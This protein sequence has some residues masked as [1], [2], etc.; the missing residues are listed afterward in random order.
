MDV[1]TAEGDRGERGRILPGLPPRGGRERAWIADVPR[2]TSDERHGVQAAAGPVPQDQPRWRNV[3]GRGGLLPYL[4]RCPRKRHFAGGA[5][6][7]ETPATVGDRRIRGSP[8]RGDLFGMPPRKSGEARI[9]GLHLMP[10]CPLGRGAGDILP[11]VPPR[12]GRSPVRAAPEDEGRVRFLPQGTRER[13]EDGRNGS[14][15]LRMPSRDSQDKEDTSRIPGD[16]QL[17]CVPS[18]PPGFPRGRRPREAR[19][20]NIPARPALPAVPPNGGER[21]GARKNETS[22]KNARGTD[23]LRGDRDP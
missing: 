1:G 5:R 21:A 14:A 3:P 11:E 17:R 19:G 7:R 10:P 16:E 12:R 15:V 20:G 9:G 8:E 23:E 22:V 6:R 2:G 18:R 13:R 4:P